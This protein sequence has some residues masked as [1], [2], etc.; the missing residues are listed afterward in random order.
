MLTFRPATV[1][2]IPLLRELAADIWQ[3]CYKEMLAPAQ[4]DYMLKW[5]YGVEKIRAEIV[6]GMGW[7]VLEL[8]G[9]L[10]GYLSAEYGADVKL[11]KLYLRPEQQGRG[12]AQQSLEHVMELARTRGAARVILNVNK[13]NMRAIR[14]YERAGFSVVDAVVN[15]I[16]G[17][18]VMDDFIMARVITPETLP[19]TSTA[20]GG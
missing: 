13:H 4:I 8:E 6:A 1:E 7:E 16:G 17:G 9:E 19:Q 18:Y 20:F 11:H 15:D 2:D 14:A 5:M 3:R 10:I 12:F